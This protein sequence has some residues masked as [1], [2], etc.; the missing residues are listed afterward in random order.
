[1]LRTIG[2]IV[3]SFG[4]EIA[5]AVVALGL[6]AVQPR[7]LDAQTCNSDKNHYHSGADHCD[8]GGSDCTVVCG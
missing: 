8:S 7:L 1:M 3:R 4:K 5:L 2:N 6:V